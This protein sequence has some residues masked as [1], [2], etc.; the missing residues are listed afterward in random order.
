MDDPFLPEEP[1]ELIKKGEENHRD[2]FLQLKK[3]W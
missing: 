2:I 3:I 1:L